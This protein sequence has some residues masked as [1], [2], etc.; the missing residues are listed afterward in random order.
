MPANE[1]LLLPP[2]LLVVPPVTTT[3]VAIAATLRRLPAIAYCI[4][5]VVV[6]LVSSEQ[7]RA[8]SACPPTHSLT[9]RLLSFD[10]QDAITVLLLATA[11][12]YTAG[13]VRRRSVHCRIAGPGPCSSP[14]LA[15][16]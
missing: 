16:H 4:L 13:T 6:I 5:A 11:R 2:L 8:A 1:M 3:A 15:W 9:R 14:G 10:Y 7:T 12:Y